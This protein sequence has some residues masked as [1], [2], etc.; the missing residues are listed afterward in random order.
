MSHCKDSCSCGAGSLRMFRGPQGQPG[1][2][3]TIQVGKV[4]FAEA[5]DVINVGT[6]THAILDFVLPIRP[7]PI[8]TQTTL[9]VSM[10]PVDGS[11]TIDAGGNVRLM[12]IENLVEIFNRRLE[13]PSGSVL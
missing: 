1:E 12:P 9:G 5:P 8:A 7:A 13:M 3:A 2:A 11:L 4:T 10:F 6:D